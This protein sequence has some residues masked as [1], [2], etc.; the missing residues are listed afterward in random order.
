MTSSILLSVW[1]ALPERFC[2]SADL[3]R[4]RREIEARDPDT[5]SRNNDIQ[6]CTA[7]LCGK[8][9]SSIA[10]LTSVCVSL[11]T[12]G[13]PPIEFT[14]LLVQFDLYSSPKTTFGA[15]SLRICRRSVAG[16][17]PRIQG[18]S[19]GFF[20]AQKPGFEKYRRAGIRCRPD[21]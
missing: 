15:P 10:K 12:R 14:P 19:R 11:F 1:P 18:F 17:P 8:S 4:N 9:P 2:T 5:A 3:R 6:C 13:V 16:I 7:A 20:G 21:I